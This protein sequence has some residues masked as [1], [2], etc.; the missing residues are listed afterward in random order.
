MG[1]GWRCP[2]NAN[3]SRLADDGKASGHAEPAPFDESGGAVQFEIIAAV[4]MAFLI[5]VVMER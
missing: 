3:R 2:T 4:E 1:S 5:E